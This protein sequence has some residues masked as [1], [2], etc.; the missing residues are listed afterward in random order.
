[1]CMFLTLWPLPEEK[2]ILIINEVFCKGLTT[3]V[4]QLPEVQIKG[5]NYSTS[6]F[7]PIG[8]TRNRM[9]FVTISREPDWNCELE[10]LHGRW[11]RSQLENNFE[12]EEDSKSISVIEI[13]E[14]KM[15]KS[16]ATIGD[17]RPS[18]INK[19]Q[20]QENDHVL[21]INA[22]VNACS[23]AASERLSEWSGF[24]VCFM[25]HIHV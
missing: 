1:M 25:I 14:R 2:P 3:A 12:I 4:V 11:I 16:D 24:H 21:Q 18:I 17:N 8:S 10:Q 20:Q 22:D 6:K 5:Q 15:A 13:T 23:S 9:N 7:P 19:A